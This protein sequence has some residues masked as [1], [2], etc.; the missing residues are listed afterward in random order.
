MYI[1]LYLAI[2][3][4]RHDGANL[5]M[6][7]LSMIEFDVDRQVCMEETRSRGGRMFA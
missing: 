6:A 4:L 5:V 1:S 2:I 3:L 7:T